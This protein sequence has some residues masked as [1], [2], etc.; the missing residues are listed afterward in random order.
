MI[1]VNKVWLAISI[2]SL[3]ITPKIAQAQTFD[4]DQLPTKNYQSYPQEIPDKKWT[5]L[6]FQASRLYE[7]PQALNWND[8]YFSEAME[9]ERDGRVLGWYREDR[10]DQDRHYLI[11]TSIQN[12]LINSTSHSVLFVENWNGRNLV[13]RRSGYY[14][15]YADSLAIGEICEAAIAEHKKRI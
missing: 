5:S 8:K 11:R 13:E 6:F 7:R 2:F 14:Y 4:L 12:C 1:F 10:N 15:G 9:L 3:V